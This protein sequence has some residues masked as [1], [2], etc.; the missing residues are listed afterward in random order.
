MHDFHHG[1]NGFVLRKGW[2]LRVW[3][4]IDLDTPTIDVI[5][6]P[7]AAGSSELQDDL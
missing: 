5:S 2:Y 6:N 4:C 7:S 3:N 1:L